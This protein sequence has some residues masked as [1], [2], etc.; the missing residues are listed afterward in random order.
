LIKQHVA[1]SL[2]ALILLRGSNTVVLDSGWKFHCSGV[3]RQQSFPWLRWGYSYL[4]LATGEVC[5]WMGLTRWKSVHVHVKILRPLTVFDTSIHLNSS[6]S[7][8]G[9]CGRN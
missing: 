6:S 1:K 8:P 5:W 7:D 9:I 3:V 4:W 2:L